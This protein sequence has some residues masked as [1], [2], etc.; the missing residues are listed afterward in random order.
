MVCLGLVGAQLQ[1][2]GR[3]SETK[4][5]ASLCKKKTRA[6]LH[7]IFDPALVIRAQSSAKRQSRTVTSRIL[8]F[9]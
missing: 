5:R 8:L 1:I 7:C 2:L 3:N 9:A 4:V 6:R